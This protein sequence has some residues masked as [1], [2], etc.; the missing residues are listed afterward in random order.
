MMV[1]RLP[2]FSASS[3]SW[4][5]KMIVF[6]RSAW[7][8]SSSSCSLVLIR[9]SSAENG[10]SISRIGASVAKARA[11]PTRCCMPPDSSCAYLPAHCDRPTSS[12]C[13]R[14]RS[15]LSFSGTPA[16]SRPNPTFSATVRH[17][18]SANCWKTIATHSRRILRSVSGP[19]ETTSA[20]QS[21]SWTITSPRVTLFNPFTARSRVDLPEPDR[22]IKTEISPA[23]TVRSQSAQPSTEPVFPRISWRVAPPSSI[24]SASR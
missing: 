7:S 1:I 10:S 19:H 22:P 24:A 20:D 11:S 16:S 3:R 15:R 21:P 4:L 12:S 18:S 17:G 2:I 9:G 8:W 5:T 23:S 13:A 6:L 14:T